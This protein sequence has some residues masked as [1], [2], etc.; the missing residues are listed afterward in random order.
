VFWAAIGRHD[1]VALLERLGD[2]VR[3]LHAKDGV[4]GAD[5]HLPGA[6]GVVLDQRPA[7]AGDLDMAAILAAAPQTEYAVVE[8][9]YYDGDLFRAIADSAAALRALGVR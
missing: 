4:I 2:R 5:P 1:P 6:E 9:D 3:L 7:G 8:F